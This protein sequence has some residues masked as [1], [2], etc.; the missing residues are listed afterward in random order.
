M[1]L[2]YIAV[3][4]F[5]EK[6]KAILSI[7]MSLESYGNWKYGQSDSYNTPLWTRWSGMIG[8][9]RWINTCTI[10]ATNATILIERKSAYPSYALYIIPPTKDPPAIPVCTKSI[11]F[12]IN[13]RKLES[14]N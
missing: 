9:F 13:V 3:T 1:G 8:N 2:E 4:F 12:W 7:N 11:T 10:A 14:T 5:A 6:N